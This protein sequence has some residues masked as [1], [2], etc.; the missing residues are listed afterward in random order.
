MTVDQLLQQA[1]TRQ[2]VLEAALVF[3]LLVVALLYFL[4]NPECVCEHCAFHRHERAMAAQRKREEVH[5]T[6]HKG[7]GASSKDPD[8]WPCGDSECPRNPEVK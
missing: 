1:L 8:R 5:N 4:P 7:F 3:A 6:Q 2:H